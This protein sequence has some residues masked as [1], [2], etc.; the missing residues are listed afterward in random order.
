MN[1]SVPQS[2]G[3]SFL[4]CEDV[5]EE[6]NNKLSV[7]GVFQNDTIILQ[8]EVLIP[9]LMAVLFARGGEG[10]CETKV[11][12]TDPQGNTVIESPKRT[13][14]LEKDT[15]HLAAVR[16]LAPHLIVGEYKIKFFFDD[17]TIE[18]SFQVKSA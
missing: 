18:R 10:S 4:V 9:S 11:S 8:E 7:I 5:R 14:V 13:V 6:V 15:F 17:E 16:V 3:S 1:K 12:L 2:N